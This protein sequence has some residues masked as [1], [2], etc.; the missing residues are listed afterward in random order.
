MCCSESLWKAPQ[1]HES[2]E[3]EF[4]PKMSAISK[5][6]TS[7]VTPFRRLSTEQQQ[8]L[9]EKIIRRSITD[10][11]P[12]SNQKK[13]DSVVVNGLDKPA[14]DVVPFLSESEELSS[15]RPF[16]EQELLDIK[17]SFWMIENLWRDLSMGSEYILPSAMTSIHQYL[18]ELGSELFKRLFMSKF[19][20]QQVC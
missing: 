12:P 8:V 9:S 5:I 3:A 11:H 17:T 15:H 18:G 20:S 19:V 16:A 7:S 10:S 6:P 14:T 2:L 13:Q 1:D 4:E